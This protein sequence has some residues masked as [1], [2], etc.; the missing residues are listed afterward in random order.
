MYE[1]RDIQCSWKYEQKLLSTYVSSKEKICANRGQKLRAKKLKFECDLKTSGTT[2]KT[3]EDSNKH[4]LCLTS[5]VDFYGT[6]GETNY[7]NFVGNASHKN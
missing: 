6:T 5:R 2:N 3:N 4:Q 1:S 7:Q